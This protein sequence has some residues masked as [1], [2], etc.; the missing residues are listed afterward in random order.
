MLVT[1]ESRSRAAQV[2]T[3]RYLVN[4]DTYYMVRN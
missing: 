2:P 4:P 3:V 1:A